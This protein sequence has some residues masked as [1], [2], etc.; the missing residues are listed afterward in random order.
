MNMAP[1]QAVRGEPA[2][3]PAAVH[4]V[5]RSPGEALDPATRAAVSGRFGTDFGS[6]RVHADANAAAS[7]D[8]VDAE[9][10][11][12]GRHIAFAAGRFT[13]TEER[14]QRLLAHELVHVMQSGGADAAGPIVLGDR[15]AAHERDASGRARDG[16][17]AHRES[18]PVLRRQA[19]PQQSGTAPSGLDP[20]ADAIVT[21]AAG[22]APESARAIQAVRSI[23]ATYFAADSGL[24]RDVVFD[25]NVAGLSTTAVAGPTATGVITVG[26][27]FLEG[28][29]RLHFA[30]RVVQVDH[31]LEHVRQHRQ[32]IGGP[33]RSSE[34]EYLAFRREAMATPPTGT[35]RLQHSERVLIVDEA[36]SNYCRLSP[37]LQTQHAQERDELLALRAR[38]QSASGNPPTAPPVCAPPS[39]QGGGASNTPS[40]RQGGL[41]GAAPVGSGSHDAAGSVKVTVPREQAAATSSSPNAV[42]QAAQ[43]GPTADAPS[44]GGHAVGQTEE[45]EPRSTIFDRRYRVGMDVTGAGTFVPFARDTYD[46]ANRATPRSSQW[47]SGGLLGAG[48]VSGGIGG[49]LVF[50]G[51]YAI[52][53]GSVHFVYEPTVGGSISVTGITTPDGRVRAADVAALSVS[54]DLIHVASG[55]ID[56]H[57]L[58]L[59]AGLGWNLTTN[60]VGFGW[61]ASPLGVEWHFL[62]SVSGT[63]SLPF[64]FT[65]DPTSHQTSVT[66]GPTLTFT[67]NDLPGG[68]RKPTEIPDQGGLR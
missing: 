41:R 48:D 50:R 34:R 15:N 65:P 64:T 36:L 58:N 55:S 31:E 20:R 33:A 63:I 46:P 25:A 42:G 62:D 66:F 32:G 49:A 57:V 24:V 3:A 45:E 44:G 11:T 12:V 51:R 22:S 8:A 38:E 54:T 18:A 2:L 43:Q 7:A 40:A 28:T 5:L 19:R 29:T 9:A 35:G 39:P 23:V 60:N 56:F 6:I 37:Q 10:Y 17:P 47:R 21:A 14:G 67:W 30:H 26:R 53:A 16:A 1:E 68:R 27:Q 59:A 61:S 13:P 4:E 52:R